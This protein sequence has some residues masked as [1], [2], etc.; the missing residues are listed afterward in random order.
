MGNAYLRP[1][2]A[3]QY[4]LGVLY[5]INCENRTLES[6]HIGVDVYYNYVKD[7]IVAYPK[8]QQFRWTMLNLGEVDIRGID[9]TT[10]VTFRFLNDWRLTTKLQYTYQE[11]I[12][13]TNPVDTYYHDQIPYIPWHSGS[14]IAMLNWK[15]WSMNYSFIYV[16]KRYNQQENI[17]YNYTQPWYTSDISFAKSIRMKNL[18][19]KFS[20]EIN[21]LLSQ[22]YDVILNYPMPKRNYR[23]R[24]SIEI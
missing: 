15:S 18:S 10:M 16:G 11:A 9:L 8:G 3:E 23:F 5:D 1:E 19:L 24:M 17:R 7:K 12:D 22:D 21:N 14:A 6:F 2:Y 13:I 4:N 20:A